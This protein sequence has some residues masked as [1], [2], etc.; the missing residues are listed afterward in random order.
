MERG[1]G[2]I[3]LLFS[4]ILRACLFF[5]QITK[6][7]KNKNKKLFSHNGVRF[8]L[9]YL[10]SLHF[11]FFLLLLIFH[12]RTRCM[13]KS[14]RSREDKKKIPFLFLIHYDHTRCTEK[15]IRRQGRQQSETKKYLITKLIKIMRAFFFK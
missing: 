8:W 5:L 10:E 7:M 1:R 2:I 6:K 4:L 11:Q 12:D 3:F 14:I 13:A 9:A 15:S